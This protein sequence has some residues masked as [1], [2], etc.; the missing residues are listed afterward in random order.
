[1][2]KEELYFA[3]AAMALAAVIC[4]IT[5]NASGLWVLLILLLIF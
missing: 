1:M 5:G 3:L 2:D 4:G